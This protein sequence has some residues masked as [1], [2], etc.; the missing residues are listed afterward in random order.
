MST[1]ENPTEL[2]F[3]IDRLTNSVQDTVSGESFETEVHLIT[4]TDLKMVTRKNG[5]KFNWRKEFGDG[6]KTVC[7]LT[8]F[9]D[10]ELIQGL[11]SISIEPDHVYMHLLENAPFNVGSKKRF[12]GV[13]GNLVAHACRVSFQEGFDGFVAFTSKTQLIDHYRIVLGA[14]LLNGQRMII[15][16]NAARQLVRKYFK[17]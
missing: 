14:V 12:N 4:R 15:P 13:A 5:W 6:R 3:E 17:Q 1:P 8:L 7:K 16:E 2:E 11:L 9:N 10:P